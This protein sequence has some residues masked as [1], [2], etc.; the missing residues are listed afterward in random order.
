MTLYIATDAVCDATGVDRRTDAGCN[1]TS[2]P[3]SG[4]N[5]GNVVFGL[6]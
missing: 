1:I 5:D 4:F 3:L 6:Q 2:A